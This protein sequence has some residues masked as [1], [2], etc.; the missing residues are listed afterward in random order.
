MTARVELPLVVAEKEPSLP[1]E[2]GKRLL[3]LAKSA[4]LGT[5]AEIAKELG[6][7]TKT[8][9]RLSSGESSIK[10]GRQFRSMLVRKGVKEAAQLSLDPDAPG[11]E[12]PSDAPFSEEEWARLGYVISKH[13]PNIMATV[14]SEIREYGRAC[15]IIEQQLTKTGRAT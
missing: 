8:V 5:Q 4:Q 6:V 1:K 14:L 15:E 10:F 12:P 13:A 3:D 7:S 9:E 11:G 2:I